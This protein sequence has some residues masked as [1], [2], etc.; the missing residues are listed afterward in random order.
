MP[1]AMVEEKSRLIMQNKT[2]LRI[3]RALSMPDPSPGLQESISEEWKTSRSPRS[4]TAE[5]EKEQSMFLFC[6]VCF[7]LKKEGS[8]SGTTGLLNSAAGQPEI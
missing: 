1:K 3:E 2:A 5:L 4:L 7:I 8:S 6:S